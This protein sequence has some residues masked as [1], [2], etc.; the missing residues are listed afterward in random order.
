M[1][2]AHGNWFAPIVARPVPEFPDRVTVGVV[3][4]NGRIQRIEWDEDLPRLQGI[5]SRDHR[6]LF[7]VAIANAKERIREFQSLDDLRR[8]LGVQFEVAEPIELWA[9]L[10]NQT[11]KSL[12]R[13]YLAEMKSNRTNEAT[14]IK[15]GT[16]VLDIQVER[17]RPKHVYYVN[18]QQTL[19]DLYGARLDREDFREIP[20]IR[21][22]ARAGKRDMIFNSVLLPAQGVSEIDRHFALMSRQFN[23]LRHLVPHIHR[24]VG[25]EVRTVGVVQPLP[26]EASDETKRFRNLILEQWEPL[27]DILVD[28]RDDSDADRQLATALEWVAAAERE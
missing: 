21:R 1:P 28:A 4:G 19:A 10:T 5:M 12:R 7:A 14:F 3:V 20:K 15:M 23:D 9:E 17:V 13:V 26:A 6:A 24:R 25:V 16:K 2:S 11:L 8:A 27:T 18:K 22:L